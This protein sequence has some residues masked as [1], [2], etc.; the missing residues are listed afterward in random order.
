QSRGKARPEICRPMR[1]RMMLLLSLSLLLV[2]PAAARAAAGPDLTIKSV[3]VPSTL[4]PGDVVKLGDV[5]RNSGHGGAKKTKTRFVL[6]ADARRD[7]KDAVL[8]TRTVATLKAGKL[9]RGSAQ[10]RIPAS[11]KT[12]RAYVIACA[13]VSAAVKERSERNNCKA[14]AVTVR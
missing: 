8:A 6:S 13:D 5:T 1:S 9:A 11:A 2:L 4:T 12:G 7:A 10:G 3:S 14:V